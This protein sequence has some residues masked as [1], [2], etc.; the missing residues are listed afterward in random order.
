VA[1]ITLNIP[2]ASSARVIDALCTAG[3]WHSGLGVTKAVFAK[4]EVARLVRERVL[5]VE[6]HALRSEAE[7]Q[8][9]ALTPPPVD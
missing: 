1:S 5:E 9:A 7:G 3:H 8:V 6:R 2:D 4:A